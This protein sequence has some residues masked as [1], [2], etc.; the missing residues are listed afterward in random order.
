[1]KKCYITTPIYYPNA[2]PH[3][4]SA[5]TT[6]IAD[7]LARVYREFNYETFFL[8]GLD[9]HGEKIE[10]VAKENKKEPKDFVDEM[11]KEFQNAWKKLDISYDYFIRTSDENHKKKVQKF[12]NEIKENGDIY[13]GVYNG[14]YCVGCERYYTEKD[15]LE[16]FVCPLHLKKV[17]KKSIESYFFRL[18]KYKEALIEFYNKNPGF[19]RNI[20]IEQIMNS[21]EDLKDLSISRPKSQLT[22]GIEIPFDK[23][24]VVY[25]WFDALLNYYTALNENK[26]LFWPPDIQLVGKDIVWFHAVIW[27][28]M[29]I[30]NN[31]PLP[32][33]LYSH[34]FLTVDGKKMSKSL[35]NVVDPIEIVEKYSS[36]T[37]RYYLITKIGFGEDGDFSLNAFKEVH[38]QELIGHYANLANRLAKLA[39]SFGYKKR[40]WREIEKVKNVFYE[41]EKN[42]ESYNVNGIIRVYTE[43]IMPL[44]SDVNM[45][46]NKEQPW[47]KREN[48]KDV[49]GECLN[50]FFHISL[51]LKPLLPYATSLIIT[52]K[53]KICDIPKDESNLWIPEKENYIIY[54]K[55]E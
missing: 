43:M 17:E 16:G 34:G 21:I 22:W 33:T 44:V 18:S 4:G 26:S 24:H 13:L 51:L 47:Q 23:N 31:K 41:L 27:P 52:N 48:S 12:L 14:Y 30:A 2:K 39:H 40:K 20:S 55:V 45:L 35:G 37:L 1:M 8:T 9:E 46:L 10:K 29:L 25:V 32:R 54:K 11:A 3:L 19:L 28:A 50:A 42:V 49:I 53:S 7:F 36:D 6:I 5:Y 15:L 38:N